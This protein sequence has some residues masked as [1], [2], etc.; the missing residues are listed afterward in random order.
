MSKLRLIP[1]TQAYGFTNIRT[2]GETRGKLDRVGRG[3]SD[4]REARRNGTTVRSGVGRVGRGESDY[5]GVKSDKQWVRSEDFEF[6]RH[7]LRGSYVPCVQQ[8]VF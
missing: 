7:V 8:D 2:Q 4:D 5:R 1:G 3:E 6:R